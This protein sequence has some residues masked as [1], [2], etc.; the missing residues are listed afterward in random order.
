MSNVTSYLFIHNHFS[1][2]CHGVW[3]EGGLVFLAA[4][5]E[6]RTS[7]ALDADISAWSF[8]HHFYWNPIP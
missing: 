3:P 6:L 2:Y 7:L 1:S 5:L 4:S 8:P